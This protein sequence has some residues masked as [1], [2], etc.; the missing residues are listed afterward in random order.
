MKT[1]KIYK[2]K[3]GKATPEEVC[4]R[5]RKFNYLKSVLRYIQNRT[6]SGTQ[7]SY[8]KCFICES[9]HLTDPFKHDFKYLI[10]PN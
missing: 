7:L 4:K 3:T 6:E 1:G 9:Y 5:K 8:Y 2:I 10:K